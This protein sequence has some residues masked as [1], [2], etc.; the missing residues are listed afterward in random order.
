MF[1][2]PPYPIIGE[3]APRLFAGLAEA[4]AHAEDPIVV[5]EYPGEIE[6]APEGW[7][8]IKRIGRGARQPTAG[9]FRRAG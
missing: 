8:L 1:V 2:D 4:T 5:F 9:F 6:L 7:T 3:V